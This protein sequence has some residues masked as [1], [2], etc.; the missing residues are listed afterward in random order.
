MAPLP[1]ALGVRRPSDAET[2]VFVKPTK[3]KTLAEKTLRRDNFTCRY[4]GFR[5][6]QYQR[7]I[8]FADDDPPFVTACSF[9]EQCIMLDRAGLAGAGALVWLPEIGQAELH[10]V[11]R[12]IYVA[13]AAKAEMSDAATRALDALMAR[14][15]DAKKRLGSDDPLLLATAM[16]EALTDEEY[17][18]T[19]A[20]LEGIRLLPLDKRLVRTHKGDINQFPNMVKY[21]SS[22]AG[23]F[24]RL[25]VNQWMDLF[26]KA[27]AAVGHA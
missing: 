21:W 1:L 6:E 12:A 19:S 8:P 11:M 5:A 16:H 18:G 17:K 7:I 24:G 3:F 25:P 9:C 26:K 4:C 13:R 20:K 14:R 2:S 10:H 23:P 15:T 22:P 27:T